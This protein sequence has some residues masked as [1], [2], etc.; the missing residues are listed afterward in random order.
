MNVSSKSTLSELLYAGATVTLPNNVTLKGDTDH[1][2][3][4]IGYADCEGK[5]VPEGLWSMNKN[6]LERALEDAQKIAESLRETT[7]N[8]EVASLKPL[9]GTA[10]P[11]HEQV[12]ELER[13]YQTITDAEHE[14][15]AT[16]DYD[17]YETPDGK[18]V[19][20]GFADG[21]YALMPLNDKAA[22]RIR[23]NQADRKRA[24][25]RRPAAVPDASSR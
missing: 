22:E 12:R 15:I 17:F 2:Y 7:P 8:I 5:W 24:G 3:I 1:H 16:G 18:V 23:N 4:E 11:F 25:K 20:A 19:M 10:K 21:G 13:P 9:A 14:K 6:G